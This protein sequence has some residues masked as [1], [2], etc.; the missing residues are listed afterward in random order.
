MASVDHKVALYRFL[1]RVMNR[2]FV[3]SRLALIISGHVLD[4]TAFQVR[5]IS[6]NGQAHSINLFHPPRNPR[7][8]LFKRPLSHKQT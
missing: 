2:T 5:A 7:P 1:R 3:P 4:G 6:G 8:I